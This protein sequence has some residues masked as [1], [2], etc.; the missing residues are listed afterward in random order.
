MGRQ[1]LRSL[2]RLLPAS[3]RS[4]DADGHSGC[5]EHPSGW[6]EVPGGGEMVYD[7][8]LDDHLA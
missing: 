3:V 5:L 4:Y 8:T 6:A 7:E 1:L 2:E